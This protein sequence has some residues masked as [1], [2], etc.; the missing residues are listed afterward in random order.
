[1]EVVKEFPIG[2]LKIETKNNKIIKIVEVKEPITNT[3]DE[4]LN[5]VIRELN[6][7]FIGKRKDFSFSVEL[8][9]TEFEK[10]V[11]KHLMNVKYGSMT[12]Y[13]K[14]AEDVK[15]KTYSRAVARV[16]ANNQLLIIVPCHRVVRKD[17][18]IGGFRLGEENK[19]YLLNL[20]KKFA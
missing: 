13:S 4:L 16:V 11:L 9:G 17:G 10:L 18:N 3:N 1:M 5:K 14:I 7:Y 20:E 12:S 2:R 8:T 6:E 19:R 15:S